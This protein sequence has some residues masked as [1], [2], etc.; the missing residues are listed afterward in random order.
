MQPPSSQ[1]HIPLCCPIIH[2]HTKMC[3]LSFQH[4]YR[5]IQIDGQR[6]AECLAPAQPPPPGRC[7]K[8]D[9]VLGMGRNCGWGDKGLSV[10][11]TPDSREGS[12]HSKCF[13]KPALVSSLQ[14]SWAESAAGPSFLPQPVLSPASILLVCGRF[15]QLVNVC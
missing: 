6:V 11:W 1:A 5:N 3:F 15:L 8:G 7:W 14:S 12:I 4:Q 13:Q 9:R 10:P 2:C